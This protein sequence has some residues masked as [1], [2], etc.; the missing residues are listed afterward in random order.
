MRPFAFLV[1]V[2]LLIFIPYRSSLSS[3][4]D[5]GYKQEKRE[6]QR[7]FYDLVN[8]EH[9]M[10][11]RPKEGTT[12]IFTN[13]GEEVYTQKVIAVNE[14][15]VQITFIVSGAPTTQIFEW[16]DDEVKLVYQNSS[17]KDP[18]KNLLG[19]FTPS[20]EIEI[21]FSQAKHADWELIEKGKTI[22][23]PFGKF[24][25]VYV[26]QKVTDEVEDAKTIYTRYYAPGYGIVK[27]TF[28]LI[29]E[30]GYKDE[31]NLEIVKEMGN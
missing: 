29:G 11:Y 12:N 28:Q 9:L 30:S 21:I 3:G 26:V 25:D 20:N 19:D 16:T 31:A 7:E 5:N 4:L 8:I 18:S 15:Y 1:I 6:I 14:K 23:V 2:L 24:K 10:D 13:E 17:P 27:E 22:T